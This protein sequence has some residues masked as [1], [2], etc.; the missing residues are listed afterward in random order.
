MKKLSLS[1]ESLRILQ[2]DELRQVDGGFG[3]ETVNTCKIP[4]YIT[5]FCTYPR[6]CWNT[7]G[8]TAGICVDTQTCKC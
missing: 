6:P 8:C 2:N 4:C 7:Q 3:A 1:K 5:Q